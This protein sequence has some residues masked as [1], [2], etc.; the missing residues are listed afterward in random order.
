[1]IA[2]FAT[3]K[4]GVQIPLGPL[5]IGSSAEDDEEVELLMTILGG[6]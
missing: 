1:M 5:P 4:S 6:F 3:R 2:A